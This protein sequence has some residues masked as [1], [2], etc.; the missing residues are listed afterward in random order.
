MPWAPSYA[1]AGELRDFVRIDDDADDAVLTAALAGASRMIDHAADPRPGRWRQFGRTDEPEAR[2]FTPSRRGYDVYIR[3]QWVA[4]TDEL[5]EQAVTSWSDNWRAF[6]PRATL[7]LAR[8]WG[9]T[10]AQE[11]ADVSG[12]GAYVA[13]T[14]T[15]LLPR[16]AAGQG[17]PWSSVLFTGSSMP[18]PPLIAE[19]VKV[20][21][22]WGWP[23]VPEA[24]HEAAMLQASRLVSRRDAPFGV[25]GS[26]ET[27]SE[28][29]L[30]ARLDPDVENLVRPFMRKIGTVLA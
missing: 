9:G 26:P 5:C 25:A 11:L 30:L 21:A 17:L 14:G 28:V 3:D 29:R 23:G 19:S 16:N 4:E 2:Y 13:I 15:V 24:I 1:T 22:E 8:L 18:C 6:G 10:E 12:D 7:N 20:T 27:G